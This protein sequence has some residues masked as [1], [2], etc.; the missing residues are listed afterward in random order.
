MK[1]LG[2]VTIKDIAEKTGVSIGTVDRALSN[3]EGISPKT[4]ERVLQVA[5]ELGYT[6]NRIASALSRRKSIRIGVVYAVN[7][8]DFYDYINDGVLKAAAELADFGIEVER[9]RSDVLSPQEQL[10]LLRGIDLRSYDGF[11]IN[12]GGEPT[13]SIIN[14]IIKLGIPAITFNS[15]A[16]DSDR[17]FFVGS[18]SRQSGRLGGE[19]MGKMLG[20]SGEVAV[21]GNFINTS[22]FVDRFGGFCE[23]L[24][25]E[26]PGI[27]IFPCAECYS[28]PD[29]AY[30]LALGL[31]KMKESI[32]GIFTTGYSATAGAARA[33]QEMQRSDIRLIGYDLTAN[34]VEA[35]QQ[36][37]CSAIL[38]QDPFEQANQA[39]HL[40]AKH[41]LDGWI[42]KKSH[43]FVETKA[44]FKYNLD[45]HSAD[46]F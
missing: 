10:Q 9:L 3:R 7:P 17:L 26:Y 13:T 34:T 39:V 40:L 44:I 30:E 12:S 32:T 4:K 22:T 42:P 24:Q 11:V 43:L 46:T 1:A 21:F 18:N 5:K 20:G 6:P 29:K 38:F 27:S 36:G 8:S 28:Q 31:L 19:L 41:I 2:K 45:N 37:W 23:V 14:R 33:V 35:L 25:K 15:D 16:P